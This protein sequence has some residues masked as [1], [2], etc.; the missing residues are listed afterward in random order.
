MSDESGRG[1]PGRT[2]ELLWGTREPPS[3]GPKPGLTV[4]EIV[5][6]A[7]GLAD[8]E[9]LD[10]LSMRRLATELGIGTMSL[11]RYVPG[12]AELV[13][14]MLDAAHGEVADPPPGADGWR[15]LLEHHARQAWGMHQRHP[16]AVTAYTRPVLGPN[17]L[18]GYEAMLRAFDGTGLSPGDR[19]NAAE[20]V[21]GYVAGA[22]GSAAESAEAQRRTGVSDEQWWSARES[23]WE[24]YFDVERYPTISAM[25]DNEAFEARADA[26]EFGL[27]RVLDGIE[28]YLTPAAG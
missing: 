19:V 3:R 16:W 13:D 18:D 12:K 28:A 4:E 26:F 2:L 1:D 5:R 9:G 20:L 22:A 8:A 14:L 21:A 24:R 10:A 17:V 23:F 7:I 6:A 27:Q 15:A 25:W 11:Y